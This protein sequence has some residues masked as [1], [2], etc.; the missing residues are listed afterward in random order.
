MES[1][2]H[3]TNELIYKTETDPKIKKKKYDYQ[4][5]E[6]RDKLRVWD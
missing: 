5:E 3:G 6:G 2:K 1:K 4:K